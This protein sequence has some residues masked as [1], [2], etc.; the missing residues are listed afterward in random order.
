MKKTTLFYID[1]VIWSLRDLTRI[2]PESMFDIP[3]F[4]MLKKAHDDYGFKVQLNLFYRTDFY[5]GDDE[6]TLADVTADY[7]S[8]WEANSDW[9]KLAFHAKQEFPD[10]PYVN[11]TYETVK[12]NFD[13][14]KSEIYR[15]AGEKS[16]SCK[17]CCNHW[18]PMSKAGCLALVDSG[19]KILAATYGNKVP[20]NGDPNS[21]PYGHAMRL[22]NNKQPET[23]TFTRITAD[24]AI[25]RSL[26]SQNHIP[27]D[28]YLST[29]KDKS[30]YV[31]PETGLGLKRLCQG[32]VTNLYETC[33]SLIEKLE[34]QKDYEFI[35]AATHEQYFYPD[36]LAYQ[37]NYA[38]KLYCY[39]EW[40]LKN[41]FKFINCEDLAD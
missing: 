8:E 11:A 13:A 26:C 29:L 2:H 14:I 7:K 34:E 15:F 28:I 33:E 35:G 12:N 25:S 21:L 3:F 19:V 27:E 17:V 18:L 40:V 38:E 23:A 10:Y 22:L 9:L 37:P 1:D 41:G 30:Y 5:Y 32:V 6:F 39:C 31:D 20:Y 24:T 16:F 36:Y 4:K